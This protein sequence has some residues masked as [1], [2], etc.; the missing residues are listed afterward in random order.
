M[1]ETRKGLVAALAGRAGWNVADQVLSSLSNFALSV[2]VARALTTSGYG[3]F[4]LSFS[5]YAY[6]LTLSRLLSQPLMIR[7]SGAGSAGLTAGAGQAA[8]AALV[9]GALAGVAMLVVGLLLR[10]TAGWSIATVGVL[11]PGLLVQDCYRVLFFAS[12]RPAAAAASDA[13]WGV[14]QL[15]GVVGVIA[16]GRGGPE[17][18]LLAW[19]LAGWLSAV[20]AAVR[21]GSGPCP[22]RPCGGCVPTTT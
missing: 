1:T 20:W 21:S 7:Y 3:A 18:Y 14:V 6:A 5:L 11:L 10:G 12:G 13:V 19:G 17:A 16:L 15:A 8:G 9:L 22:A 4:A 2:L